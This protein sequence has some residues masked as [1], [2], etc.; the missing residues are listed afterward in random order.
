MPSGELLAA[1]VNS[2]IL[3]SGDNGDTWQQQNAGLT[4]VDIIAMT[5]TPGGSIFAGGSDGIFR[6]NNSGEDW[7]RPIE[8]TIGLNVN[9][10]S[11]NASGRLLAS[12]NG[13]LAISDDNGDSW[14]V[15]DRSLFVSFIV[16]G[17]GNDVYMGNSTGQIFKSTDDGDT[18]IELTT[19]VPNTTVLTI[20]VSN[21]GTIFAGTQL[22]GVF[23]STDAGTTWVEVSNGL[24]QYFII[25]SF[26]FQPNGDV[27]LSAFDGVFRSSNNGDAWEKQGVVPSLAVRDLERDSA[28]N[29]FIASSGGVA[30][31]EDDGATWSNINS[32]LWHLDA[33]ALLIDETDNIY[34]GTRGGGVFKTQFIP[35]SVELTQGEFP[36]TFVLEQNYPNPFNPGTSIRYEISRATHV[37]ITVFDALGR[38]VRTLV[39]RAISAGA[40]STVWNGRDSRG[41]RVASGLYF[42]RLEAGDFQQTAKMLLVK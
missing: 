38:T 32:G 8:Q 9:D 33:K 10:I 14:I 25:T 11:S 40:H 37:T 42:Y 30:V 17:S 18:W 22:N 15:P 3:R 39:D 5:Q 7:N 12:I 2:G 4:A 13:F 1:P 16:F 21:A 28:G 35:T 26:L 31:S 20:G 19:P 36:E 34:V 27:L 24:G 29:L 41:S 23:R 6:T